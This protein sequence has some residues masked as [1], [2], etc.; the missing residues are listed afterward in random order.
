M[1][2]VQEEGGAEASNHQA[3]VSTVLPLLPHPPSSNTQGTHTGS[4]H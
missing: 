2:Q 3:S 1:F 4:D